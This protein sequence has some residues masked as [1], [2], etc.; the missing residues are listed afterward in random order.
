MAGDG[1]VGQSIIAIRLNSRDFS[2]LEEV[3]KVLSGQIKFGVAWAATATDSAPMIRVTYS[4]SLYIGAGAAACAELHASIFPSDKSHG[5]G[6]VH[7]DNLT[8]LLNHES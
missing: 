7:C 4:A 1:H 2:Y 8:E 5:F 6:A 3:Q